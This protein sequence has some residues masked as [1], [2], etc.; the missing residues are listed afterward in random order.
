M[1][2]L[3]AEERKQAVELCKTHRKAK[4]PLDKAVAQ[5]LR[6]VRRARKRASAAVNGTKQK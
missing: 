4:M 5:S 3:N 1:K 2:P 6:D